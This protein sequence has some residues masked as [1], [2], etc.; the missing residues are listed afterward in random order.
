MYVGI[1]V[2][3]R[4]RNVLKTVFFSTQTFKYVGRMTF[5]RLEERQSYGETIQTMLPLN[6]EHKRKPQPS[7]KIFCSTKVGKNF[8]ACH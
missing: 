6:K 2:N 5:S 3:I 4:G 8:H 1:I 7:Y